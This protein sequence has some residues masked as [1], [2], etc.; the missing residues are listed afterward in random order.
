MKTNVTGGRRTQRP[1]LQFRHYVVL[2][3]QRLLR[4][5]KC[6]QQSQCCFGYSQSSHF[7]YVTSH[8]LASRKIPLNL[9]RASE[10]PGG[11]M[12]RTLDSQLKGSRFDSRPFG[13]R[14]QQP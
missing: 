5:S 10:W 8:A 6:V 14:V 4:N 13:F 3:I 2:Q 1:Q 9:T 12:V 7:H 11:V